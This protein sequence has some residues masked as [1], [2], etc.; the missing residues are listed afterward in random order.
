MALQRLLDTGC[1]FHVTGSSVTHPNN[2]LAN[3]TE[4]ELTIKRCH[5]NQLGWAD[6]RQ[7]ADTFEGL[8][9]QITEMA[10]NGLEDGNRGFWSP[11]AAFHDLVNNLQVNGGL[12]GDGAA[13]THY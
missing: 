6:L 2:V 4:P 5:T 11:S 3:R 10:L 13:G 12:R 1:P 7:F 9:G 8:L